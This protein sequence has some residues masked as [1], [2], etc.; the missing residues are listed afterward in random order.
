MVVVDGGF[1]VELFPCPN[2][3]TNRKAATRKV[4]PKTKRMVGELN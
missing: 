4:I 1:V 2:T 3:P